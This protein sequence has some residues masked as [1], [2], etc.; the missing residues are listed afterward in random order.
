MTNLCV[1]FAAV[2]C[3]LFLF[4]TASCSKSEKQIINSEGALD[5]QPK[6]TS[7]KESKTTKNWNNSDGVICVLLGYGF[8]DKTFDEET[9]TN[10]SNEFGLEQNGGLICPLVYPDDF[11]KGNSARIS[12]LYYMIN[13]KNIKGILLLG[14]PENTNSVLARIQDDW[15]GKPPYPVF[16]LFP[17][18][19]VLGMEA[20]CDFVLDY[21]RSAKEDVLNEETTLSIDKNIEKI[22]INSVRYIAELPASLPLDKDLSTHVQ[23]IVGEDKK[24]RRFTDSETGLQS[25]NHFVIEKAQKK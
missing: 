15:N 7:Q 17:Q 2:S 21:E 3:V 8:N 4:L 10:L 20:T 16:S 22:L 13:E 14:A 6:E 12:E 25:M 18:D 1:K 19:D 24:V 23:Q 11:K 9:F 5:I